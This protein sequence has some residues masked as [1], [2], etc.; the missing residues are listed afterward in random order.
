MSSK[1]VEFPAPFDPKV[2]YADLD[3]SACTESEPERGPQLVVR[4]K[5]IMATIE[6]LGGMPKNPYRDFI[7]EPLF[8]DPQ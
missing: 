2:A 8:R 6:R 4:I 5:D 7:Y 3:L 1:V